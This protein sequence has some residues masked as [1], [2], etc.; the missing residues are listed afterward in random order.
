MPLKTE[1]ASIGSD[2]STIFGNAAIGALT[3]PQDPVGGV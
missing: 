3:G 2:E 1:L